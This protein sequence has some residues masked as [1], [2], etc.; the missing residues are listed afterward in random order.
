MIVEH[1][2]GTGVFL[3]AS[4]EFGNNGTSIAATGLTAQQLLDAA[5]DP[6]LVLPDPLPVG[7]PGPALF[8]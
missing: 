7:E 5:A 6:R 4:S 2:D 1:E 3:V 8:R